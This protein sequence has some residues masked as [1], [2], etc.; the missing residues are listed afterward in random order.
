MESWQLSPGV[1]QESSSRD[2]YREG[3]FTGCLGG[4]VLTALLW[5]PDHVGLRT[6]YLCLR[7]LR[8]PC[9]PAYMAPR[10]TAC[11]SLQGH[12]SHFGLDPAG[13]AC[14]G[15]C[16]C[17]DK[18][19]KPSRICRA[20]GGGNHIHQQVKRCQVGHPLSSDPAFSRA[21]SLVGQHRHYK[22]WLALL[23]LPHQQLH[24][25]RSSAL[26]DGH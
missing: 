14:R 13:C 23:Q 3:L 4:T 5:C 15:I 6:S 19:A 21:T 8:L 9:H 7:C 2:C 24:P 1:P 25:W 12:R 20:G 11:H 18:T 26:R 10:A 17:Q 16:G 22:A